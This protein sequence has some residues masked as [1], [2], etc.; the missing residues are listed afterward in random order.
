M[1]DQPANSSAQPEWTVYLIDDDRA[2][3]ASAQFLLESVRLPSRC[4]DSAE[5]F[6]AQVSP[7]AR[8]C[9]VTD[10]RMPGLSGIEL[11]QRLMQDGSTLPVILVTGH[12]D[13]PMAVRA[14]KLGA[15]DFLEKPVH[16]QTLIESIQRALGADRRASAV[17]AGLASVRERFERLSGREHEVFGLVVQGLANK[18]IAAELGLSEKT[19]EIHRAGV[20]RKMDAQSLAALV[21]MAVEL[22]RA[23]L[24]KAG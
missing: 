21:R 13:V 4:F 11:Q 15:A 19:V 24:A 22:E 20:M 8:G 9:V 16:A 12:G 23:G 14:L 3:L 2:V 5:A 6:L 7:Q 17:R 18:Q 10:L 1:K